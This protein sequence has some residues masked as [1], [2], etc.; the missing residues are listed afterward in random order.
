[1][2]NNK[3]NSKQFDYEVDDIK[4]LSKMVSVIKDQDPLSTDI[5]CFPKKKTKFIKSISYI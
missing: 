4:F 5:V 1:M 2:T 3:W